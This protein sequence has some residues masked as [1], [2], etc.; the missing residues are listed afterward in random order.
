MM[1]CDRFVRRD[2]IVKQVSN[3]LIM[4]LGIVIDEDNISVIVNETILI[5]NG[6]GVLE[7]E[8]DETD[9]D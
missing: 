8:Y 9:E 1:Y 5:L 7:L 2:D 4:D 6:L 3:N